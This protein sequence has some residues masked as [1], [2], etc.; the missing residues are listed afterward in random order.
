VSLESRV[1]S[2]TAVSLLLAAEE[3]RGPPFIHF[4]GEQAKK[5]GKSGG[6]LWR[7]TPG[8]CT[9]LWLPYSW[10]TLGY[11]LLLGSFLGD[12]GFQEQHSTR[13]SRTNN[14]AI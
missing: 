7:E 3:R 11:T 4:S 1:V 8:R 6:K 13:A 9:V 12:E 14:T 10:C 2:R 5:E